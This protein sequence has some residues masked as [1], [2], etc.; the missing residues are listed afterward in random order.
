MASWLELLYALSIINMH[1]ETCMYKNLLANNSTASDGEKDHYPSAT[2]RC[3]KMI[4][5]SVI[6][7][8]SVYTCVIEL[9]TGEIM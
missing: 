5:F 4:E 6:F 3:N 7:I 8:N 2:A 1:N 9:S